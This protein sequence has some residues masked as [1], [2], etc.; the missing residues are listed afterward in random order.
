MRYAAIMMDIDGTL[1]KNVSQGL[2]TERVQSAIRAAKEKAHVGLATARPFKKVVPIFETLDLSGPSILSGGAQLVNAP[3]EEYYYER[4]IAADTVVGV[5][6]ILSK[7]NV[8]FW[9][10]DNGTDYEFDGIYKPNKPFVIVVYG[11]SENQVKDIRRAIP[12]IADIAFHTVSS[13]EENKF[14]IHM[15][16]PLATKEHGID[17]TAKVLGINKSQIIGVGDSNNDIPLLQSCG[18]KVA[19]G[20]ATEDVKAIADYIASTVD[21]D[22]VADVIEKFITLPH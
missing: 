20:N 7:K 17:E 4:T 11:V 6:N 19:M 12:Q 8:T 10:Q 16:D 14:D 15:T 9:V 5:C 2:P 21:E 18:L 22:G 1:M 3:R 13:P